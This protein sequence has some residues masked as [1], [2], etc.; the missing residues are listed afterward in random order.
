M[1]APRPT[2]R[3]AAPS[4]RPFVL[5]VLAVAIVGSLT[6][7]AL[8]GNAEEPPE[9]G[10]ELDLSTERTSE[11][12]QEPH[13]SDYDR[14]I[15]RNVKRSLTRGREA[16]RFNT[17]G[18]EAFWGGE[19]RLHE[20]L[21]TVSPNTALA[22]GLKVDSEA[23]PPELIDAILNGE[24]DLDDPAVTVDLPELNS[25]VGATG[26]FEEE[27][28]VSVG[29]QC[30]LCHSTVDDSVLPGIGQRR[31]GWANRDLDVGAIIA[32][33]PDLS[34]FIELL[35][36]DDATVRT[37]LTSWGPG[38]FDAALSLDGKAFRDDGKTAAVLIPPA[39]G[40]AGTNLQTWTGW[41]SV[42]HWNALV[43]VLEMHGDGTLID[44]RLNDPV[45]FPVATAN[46]FFEVRSETDR[47]TKELSALHLYQMA[48]PAPAPPKGSFD[49]QAASRGRQ[50]FAGKARCAECHVP[51]LYTE[52]GW[53]LHTPDEIGIDSFQAERS[54]TL[55]YR[56]APLRGLWS[57][58]KG[59]FYHD[60]RFADFD[61]LFDH[62][63]A[64]LSVELSVE[65]RADLKQFLLSL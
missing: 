63:S 33:A 56:T 14:E 35:G 48:L 26:F 51:P 36:V 54:P 41:G 31:D 23:L 17:F 40:L 65:E 3:A 16:F 37:V 9:V 61:E 24:V 32:L 11:R 62:Y 5:T 42:A 1:A 18:D 21:A 7:A 13:R 25:V 55:G 53:N 38:K 58:T 20:A 46:G 50:V 57:H 10:I 47:V 28:L 4:P 45:R 29:I 30:A 59:G 34:P 6:I 60:G 44:P 64:L 49:P 39:F 12:S 27:E 8:R 22:V 19:L 15:R 43:A 2:G 52:P